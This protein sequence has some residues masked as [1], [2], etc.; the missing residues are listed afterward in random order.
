MADERERVATA[1]RRINQAWL[2]KHVDDLASFI[3]PGITMALPGFAGRAAGRDTFLAGFRE[4]CE[5]A[6]VLYFHDSP[7][8]VDVVS[9]TAVVT[10]AY[11]MKYSRNG[12][13]SVVRGRDVWVF[14]KTNDNWLAVWRA[15]LDLEESPA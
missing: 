2:T 8:D 14:E 7:H 13:T 6:S 15:M 5:A 12:A 9:N 4:F 10:F 3:H 1:M 11:D